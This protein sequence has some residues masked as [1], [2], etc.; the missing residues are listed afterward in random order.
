MDAGRQDGHLWI[1]IADTG[2]GI[3]PDEQ[4]NIFAPFYR[5]RASGRFPQGMGLGLPI[6]RDLVL[7]HNGRLDVDSQPGRGSR[8]TIRVPLGDESPSHP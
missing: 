7:A 6:A 3:T 1:E 2:P 8:F 5:G 4:R